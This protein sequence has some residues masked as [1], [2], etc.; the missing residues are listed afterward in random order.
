MTSPATA[1]ALPICAGPD[2][3]PRKPGFAVPA[4]ACDSHAHI[5]APARV[6]PYVAERAY[7]PAE[8]SLEDYQGML[9]ALGVERAV[10]VQPSVYGTDNR[11][12]LE[13]LESGGRR[14]RGVAVCDEDIAESEIAHLHAAGVRGLRV[15]LLYSRSATLAA[16]AGLAQRIAPFGWHLQILVDVSKTPDLAEILAPLSVAVVVDHMGHLPAAKGAG[17]PGFQALLALVRGGRSWV[18]LSGAYRLSSQRTPPYADVAPLARALIAAAPERMLWASDWPHPAIAMPMP[19]DGDLLDLLAEWAPD[20]ATRRK[21]LVDNPAALYG[22]ERS[23]DRKA[24][25]PNGS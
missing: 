10:L 4:G 14:F 6:Y 8:A 20:E 23:H 7:T 19:N 11:A 24:S 15:N 13:A 1:A 17:D 3:E 22:F 18:K 21:I 12:M 25:D 2:P 9:A 16:L 5:F